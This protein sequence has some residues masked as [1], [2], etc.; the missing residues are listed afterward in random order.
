VSPVPG[1]PEREPAQASV[2]VPA[3]GD[4]AVD[5]AMDLLRRVPGT[6]GPEDGRM[7]SAVSEALQHRL[8]ATAG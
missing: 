8:S 3:T 6:G 4:A 5:E 2:E 7:L 1:T